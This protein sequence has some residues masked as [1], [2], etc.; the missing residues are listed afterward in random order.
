VY[1]S[2]LSDWRNQTLTPNPDVVYLISFYDTREG[3]VVLDIP[4]AEG[5]SITGSI[6]EA[7]QTPLV[8][9]GPAGTDKGRGGRYVIVPPGY[10]GEIPAGFISLASQTFTGFALLRSNLAS[11]SETDV[12][13]AV[14]YGQRVNVYLLADAADR[15]TTM[16]V[17][18]TDTLFDSTIPGDLRFFELLHRFIQR[19]PWLERDRAMI[20]VLRSVG[21]AKGE[22]FAADDAMRTLL[23]D[24]LGEARAWLDGRYEAMFDEPYV[25]ATHWAVPAKRELIDGFET[26]F[27]DP[28]SYPVDWRGTT[29]SYAFFSPKHLGGGQFYLMAIRDANGHGFDGARAYRLTVP[30]E[31]PVELYWSATVYDRATHALI[32]NKTRSSRASTSEGLQTNPDGSIDVYFGPKQP[33][34]KE[35]NWIPTDSGGEFEV[36]FRFYG[37]KQPLFDKSWRLPDIEKL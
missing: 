21:I 2:R 15:P 28:N 33:D 29:Y 26:H 10:D 31:A 3:P 4:P 20:D 16:F 8:D 36:M 18:A 24:A 13:A 25:E 11:A 27:A 34:G 7:W 19:E 12:A 22:E 23:A 14:A 37:P 35:P 17:N 1:W 30:A 5:G 9:V 6:D 32:R